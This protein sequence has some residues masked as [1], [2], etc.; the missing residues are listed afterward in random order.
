MHGN[1]IEPNSFHAW[2][3]SANGLAECGFEEWLF[4]PGMM[5]GSDRKWWGG[6]GPR[7]TPHEG[8]D[9]CFFRVGL[10]ATRR[11][12]AGTKI[13]AAFEGTVVHMCDDYLGKTVFVK[14]QGIADEDRHLFTI[15]GHT[16]PRPRQTP[17]RE[18]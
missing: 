8:L 16:Q 15:Y 5:F 1:P 7:T 12:L 4:D 17:D 3:L 2:L 14:H 6:G 18:K 13:P 11:L 10:S 9:L